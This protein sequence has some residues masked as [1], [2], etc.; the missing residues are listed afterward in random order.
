MTNV[1]LKQIS[2]IDPKTEDK[3]KEE[4]AITKRLEHPNIVKFM[5]LQN[6]NDKLTMILEFFEGGSLYHQLHEKKIIFPMKRKIELAI[7]ISN[8]INYLHHLILK[9]FIEI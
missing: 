1:A 3:F 8:G 9:L 2:N 5:E 6:W 7:D 4:I